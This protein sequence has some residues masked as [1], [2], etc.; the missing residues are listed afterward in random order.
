MFFDGA[1]RQT[2][3]V[4]PARTNTPLHALTTLN[5]TT[6]VEAARAMAERVIRSSARRDE[7]IRLAFRLAT[8]RQPREEEVALLSRRL[9]L[10]QGDFANQVDDAEALLGVG[11]SPRDPEMDVAEHAAYAVV[12]S[13]LLNLDET[14]SRP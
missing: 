7:R 8:A 4:K 1:K 6:F 14:L 3:E 11:A 12:C 10:L 9:E 13:I 2:C 5:E